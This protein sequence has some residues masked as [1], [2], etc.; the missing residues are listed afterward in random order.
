MKTLRSLFA[1]TALLIVAAG[2]TSPNPASA[3]VFDNV[4]I[5]GPPQF[6][7]QVERALQLLKTQSPQAYLVVTNQVGII[8]QGKHSGM[9]ASQKP[10][11]FDLNDRSAF[12]S[13][14]WCAGV[15][16][17]DSFHSKLYHDYKREHWLFVPR[18]IWTGREAEAKCLEHQ[19]RVLTDISAPESEISYCKAVGPDYTDVSYRKRNW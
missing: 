16:A 18:K 19:L 12:Y 9:R 4:C 10:P 17:H 1:A 13:V 6:S 15:I 3:Q 11:V 14:T 2:C 8:R 7:A 5:Q